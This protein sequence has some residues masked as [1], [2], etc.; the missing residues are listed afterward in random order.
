MNR[1]TDKFKEF[2][3]PTITVMVSTL[4]FATLYIMTE[5]EALISYNNTLDQILHDNNSISL[6]TL[7][8][9]LL[10]SKVTF[11][12]IGMVAAWSCVE[13]LFSQYAQQLY[14]LTWEQTMF[15]PPAQ[16]TSLLSRVFHQLLASILPLPLLSLFISKDVGLIGRIL[17]GLP[18][19]PPPTPVLSVREGRVDPDGHTVMRKVGGPGFLSVGHDTAAIIAR[20]GTI[21]KVL[22]PGFYKLLPF[23]RV[24]DVV[25]L[26]PQRRDL[27][28]ETYSRDGI[29][30]RCDAKIIFQLDNG[31]EIPVESANDPDVLPKAPYEWN[32]IA[33]VNALKVTTD[34]VVLKPGG[35]RRFS[36]WDNR[37]PNGILDGIIRDEVEKYRL[38]E[39]LAPTENNKPKP[40]FEEAQKYQIDARQEA[41]ESE[42]PRPFFE[43]LE[44]VI[45]QK[46]KKRGKEEGVHVFEVHLDPILPA[47]D[48]VSQQWIESWR[49]KWDRVAHELQAEGKAMGT[50]AIKL[51]R[52]HAQAEI[53]TVITEA[54]RDVDTPNPE[55]ES[56]MILSRFLDVIR[57]FAEDDPIVRSTIFKEAEGLQRISRSITEVA[58][59]E[60]LPRLASKKPT[61]TSS[62]ES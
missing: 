47:E 56:A 46:V 57:A 29:P 12:M 37:M 35:K 8:I 1:K 50:A 30:I 34:K 39:Y 41:T 52:I 26:R 59:I 43:E 11:F 49:S 17:Y 20:G 32:N 38:D 55:L 14:N 45:A 13:F 60:L 16:E 18:E 2:L 15:P 28:V 25:D 21:V 22:D 48:A 61:I 44:T 10:T 53:I 7:L 23:E 58:G 4:I 36:T 9:Q 5:P 42:K 3:L 19:K 27:R 6:I 40:F 33:A 54:M 31:R 24:W 51:A 62:E